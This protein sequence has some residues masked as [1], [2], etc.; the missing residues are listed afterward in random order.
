MKKV[1]NAETELKKKR[2]F[3]EKACARNSIPKFDGIT[4]AVSLP[5]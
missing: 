4:I 1:S 2:C 5:P 3:L